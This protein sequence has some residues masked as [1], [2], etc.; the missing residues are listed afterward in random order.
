MIQAIETQMADFYQS[1]SMLEHMSLVN[2][3]LNIL[4]CTNSQDQ[5]KELMSN[6]GCIFESHLPD[7]HALIKKADASQEDPE[8]AKK[9]IRMR[10]VQHQRETTNKVVSLFKNMDDNISS[11]LKQFSV[12][13]LNNKKMINKLL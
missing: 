10:P 11:R 5:T 7:L 8:A 3:V 13:C 6:I 4:H 1:S 12:F 9:E 2:E